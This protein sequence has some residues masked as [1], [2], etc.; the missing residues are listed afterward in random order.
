MSKGM[1]GAAGGL[2][3][4]DR[5]KLIPENLREGVVLFAGTARE[6]VGTFWP[7]SKKF[8]YTGKMETLRVSPGDYEVEV[9]GA[10]GGAGG[11]R[12]QNFDGGAGGKGGL[13]KAKL[14][15]TAP[16]ELQ[17]YVGGV[18]KDGGDGGKDSGG[19]GGDGGWG[20]GSGS[21]GA[22]GTVSSGGR[23]G[24]GGGGGGS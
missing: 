12:Y 3:A 2:S 4:E 11:A 7:I 10:Q 9:A 5:E 24:G 19:T 21:K 23:G 13:V 16:A 17:V 20:Y 15:I 8:E 1:L 14:H 6:I 22:S 18:G